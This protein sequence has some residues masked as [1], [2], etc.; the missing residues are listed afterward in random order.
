MKS[1]QLFF[2]VFNVT[3]LS[4]PQ[5]TND[6]LKY[7]WWCV[8][9]DGLF[10]VRFSVLPSICVKICCYFQLIKAILKYT[11]SHIYLKKIQNPEIYSPLQLRWLILKTWLWW[12]EATREEL[13]LGS[14]SFSAMQAMIDTTETLKS[15]STLHQNIYVITSSKGNIFRVTGPLCGEFTGHRWIPHTKASDAEL[16]CFLWSAPWINGWVNN[17]EGGDSVRR[18][19]AHYDVMVWP[20]ILPQNIYEI[21]C[22]S[23]L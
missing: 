2:L 19:H 17:R 5:L 23:P 11:A 12:I 7:C 10:R 3:K 9:C 20:K 15:N 16:W 8:S 22:F 21:Y 13:T 1:T 4:T 6:E 14:G 18:H